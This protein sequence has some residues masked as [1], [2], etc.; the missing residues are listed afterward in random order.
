MLLLAVLPGPAD[1]ATYWEKK[2]ISEQVVRIH[3]ETLERTE[4]ESMGGVCGLQV[5]WAIFLLGINTHVEACDGNKQFDNYCQRSRTTGGHAIKAYPVEEYSLEEA[6][7]TITSCGTKD[8]YNVMVGFEWTN[9]EA[10]KEY[11]HACMIHAILD[12]YVYFTE[13]FDTSTVPE[14]EP[15]ILSIEEF[16]KFFSSWTRYEGLIVFGR[17]DPLDYCEY[18]STDMFVEAERASTVYDAMGGNALRQ[19]NVGER[20]HT[21]GMYKGTDGKYYYQLS[22]DD[23]GGYV[24]ADNMQPIWFNYD[25]VALKAF[26][27]PQQ[28]K[29]GKEYTLSGRVRTINGQLEQV[30]VVVT[31]SNGETVAEKQ[32]SK[33][34]KYCDL[35]RN[36]TVDLSALAEGQYTYSV[37][38]TARNHY[39][40]NSRISTANE[41][42]CLVNQAFAVG[43]TA[44][45]E[46]QPEEIPETRQNR[47]GWV[48]EQGTWFYYENDAP[49]TGWLCHKGLDYYL[50]ED[51]SVTTGWAEINGKLRYFSDTGAMR[52][53]WMETKDGTLYMLSNGVSA[54]G[55]RT[56]GGS[57]F[58]FDE[59]GK[60]D[61]NQWVELEG[62]LYYLMEDGKMAVGWV[63]LKSG[64]YS[65]H[66]DGHLLAKMEVT[67]SGERIVA[68]D[69]SWKPE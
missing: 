26:Q 33:N 19:V 65:F 66:A 31:D 3:Q 16:V 17:K 1:A 27:L 25:D 23:A 42:I 57:K 51:G 55:W 37:Y 40:E 43:E 45:E 69:G 64:R 22:G 52:V 67:E 12:G 9:T 14:G 41:Q 46:I 61:T 2:R 32:L 47:N 59:T 10:G 7:N 35:S 50:Q 49:K 63:E 60:L 28:I 34:G 54:V 21:V 56:I 39:L 58:H 11:G 20:L 30:K 62:N 29:P 4:R 15:I 13:G 53:G 36:E 48:Y 24:P 68:Y 38:A 44:P 8:V 6:L 5:S 18:Y